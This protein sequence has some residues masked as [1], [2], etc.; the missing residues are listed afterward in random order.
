MLRVSRNIVLLFIV[1]NQI[2]STEA[3]NESSG[4]VTHLGERENN[5]SIII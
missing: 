2:S 4:T 3:D 5:N 1:F